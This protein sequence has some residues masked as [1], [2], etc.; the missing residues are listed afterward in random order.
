L[1]LIDD[2]AFYDRFGYT[3]DKP[4]F[5][6]VNNRYPAAGRVE[7]RRVAG[8]ILRNHVTISPTH[9]SRLVDIRFTSPSAMFSASVTNAW[10][11]AFI[12]I[13]LERKLQATSYGR[14]PIGTAKGTA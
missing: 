14:T 12:Q 11:D 4:A 7:R 10:A 8:E 1:R 3:D 6:L 9:L 5:A 2:P 13:N